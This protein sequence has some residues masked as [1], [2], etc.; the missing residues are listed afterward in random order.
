MP[1]VRKNPRAYTHQL[2]HNKE[3]TIEIEKGTVIILSLPTPT[4]SITLKH[5]K[6]GDQLRLFVRASIHKQITQTGHSM[7]NPGGKTRVVV[8]GGPEDELVKAHNQDDRS[9]SD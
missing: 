4:N 3:S 7:Q 6:N 9:Q 2:E 5:E 1:E 8:I